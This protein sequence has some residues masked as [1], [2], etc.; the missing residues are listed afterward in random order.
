MVSVPLQQL[1][2]VGDPGL[3]ILGGSKVCGVIPPIELTKA[4]AKP[5]VC[6]RL[7][8]A[9]CFDEAQSYPVSLISARYLII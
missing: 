3:K 2:Q 7:E 6:L 5:I 9:L 8:A 1:P 4:I